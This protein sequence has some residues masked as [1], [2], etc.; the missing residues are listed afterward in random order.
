MKILTLD[1]P[2]I[3]RTGDQTLKVATMSVDFNKTVIHFGK[4]SGTVHVK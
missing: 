4:I 3:V 1:H 2:S